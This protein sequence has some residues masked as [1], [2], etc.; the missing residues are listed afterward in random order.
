MEHPLDRPVWSALMGPQAGVAVTLGGAVRYRPDVGLFAATVD[1]GD[2]AMAD[3][4]S[5]VRAHGETALVE[6][7]AVSAPPGLVVVSQAEC[8]QM[9]AEGGGGGADDRELERLST[10][11]W[12]EMTALAHATRPGPFFARTASLG[13]FLGVRIDGR[14]AAMAGE[15]MR[16]PGYT[17]VSGVCTLPEYRGRG[18]AAALIGAV[19]ADIR[20][21]G[22]TPILHTYASNTSANRLYEALGFRTRQ[23]VVMT[24]L[25]VS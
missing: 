3:L 25:A 9:V 14:L 5:L 18:L 6:P 11:D 4:T 24:V 22:E 13:R 15:R 12:P 17:E 19:M 1:A 20:A 21:R 2:A 10:D 23:S 16:I 8:L 7:R